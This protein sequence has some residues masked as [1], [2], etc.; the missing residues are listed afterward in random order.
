MILICIL[1]QA[2][3]NNSIPVFEGP[4]KRTQIAALD[5]Y[6]G[7]AGIHEGAGVHDNDSAAGVYKRK[8]T[9]LCVPWQ[10]YICRLGTRARAAT[11]LASPVAGPVRNAPHFES[12]YTFPV[13]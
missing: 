5:A 9:V 7:G 1:R 4:F 13:F 6:P 12:F 10:Q 2:W 11:Q 3:A 8:K